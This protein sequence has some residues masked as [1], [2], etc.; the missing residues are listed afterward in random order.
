MIFIIFY[1]CIYTYWTRVLDVWLCMMWILFDTTDISPPNAVKHFWDKWT[2]YF[3]RQ[4][5]SEVCT[6]IY[7]CRD[8]LENQSSTYIHQPHPSPSNATQLLWCPLC[9]LV[10]LGPSGSPELIELA[11]ESTKSAANFRDRVHTF[12]DILAYYGDIYKY[13]YIYTNICTNMYIYISQYIYICIYI[14]ILYREYRVQG[15]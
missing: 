6:T 11:A 3:T 13:I 15:G 5:R 8:N 7:V 12:W 1:V 14:H 4:H 2:I 10:P 9:T